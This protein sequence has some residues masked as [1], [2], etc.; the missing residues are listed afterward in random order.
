MPFY[1]KCKSGFLNL[2][3][4]VH[5]AYTGAV[6][7][8]LV[9]EA[10]TVISPILHTLSASRLLTG[11]LGSAREGMAGAPRLALSFSSQ[12][13]GVKATTCHFSFR[14]WTYFKTLRRK[15]FNKLTPSP[16]CCRANK[17]R[18]TA[19][20]ARFLLT[21]DR[22]GGTAVTMGKLIPG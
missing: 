14:F 20:T 22:A 19:T 7:K 16:T 17:T 4:Q 5:S 9:Q 15:C 1:W 2:P 3:R 18:H 12:S 6:L 8:L 11:P 13:L 21:A 10:G